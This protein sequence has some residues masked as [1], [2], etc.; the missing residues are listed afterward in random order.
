MTVIMRISNETRTNFYDLIN[1]VVH[2]TAD[3]Y[4]ENIT[5][6]GLLERRYGL[7]AK[8]RDYGRLEIMEAYKRLEAIVALV[9]QRRLRPYDLPSF[10]L[11]ESAEDETPHKRA[12]L[13]RASTKLRYVPLFSDPLLVNDHLVGELIVVTQP[14]NENSIERTVIDTTGVSVLFGVVP[15]SGSGTREGRISR[16]TVAPPFG[17]YAYN[18]WVGIRPKNDGVDEFNPMISFAAN[19]PTEIGVT[20]V[21]DANAASGHA[22]QINHNTVST[23]NALTPRHLVGLS[24]VYPSAN[25]KHWNGRYRAILRYRIV[26][27]AAQIAVKLYYGTVSIGSL[28]VGIPMDTIYLQGTNN[29]YRLIDA[30]E[31]ILPFYGYYHE[32]TLAALGAT[33]GCGF[34]VATE[35]I[36]GTPSTDHLVIDGIGLMPS[37]R[38]ATCVEYPQIFSRVN[39]MTDEDGNTAVL[40]DYGYAVEGV[41]TLTLP[42]DGGVAVVLV[43]DAG[44]SKKTDQVGLTIKAHSHYGRFAGNG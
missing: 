27:T 32:K 40:G 25:L 38:M 16:L 9:N 12:V 20:S 15:I 5:S 2:V 1:D 10:W 43:E 42:P 6:D 33:Y 37:D 41:N 21:S 35:F 28:D 44:I 14:D 17:T 13:N 3:E 11:E 23:P 31:V 34:L 18:A 4:Y 7:F 26:G 19:S 22:V 29:S 36:D 39:W 8:T 30:G 24:Q